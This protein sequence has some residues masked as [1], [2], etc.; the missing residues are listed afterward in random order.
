MIEQIATVAVYA[1]DQDE[2][3]RFRVERVG[4]EVR[5]RERMGRQGDWLEV[6]SPGAASRLVIYPKSM[7]P[8]WA[9]RKPS[10][11]PGPANALGHSEDRGT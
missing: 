6:A 2:A 5:R 9:E 7:M 8:D 1:D 4:F 3:Q 11:C 10:V